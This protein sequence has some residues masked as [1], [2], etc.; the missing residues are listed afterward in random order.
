MYK[1][2]Q[3]ISWTNNKPKNKSFLVKHTSSRTGSGTRVL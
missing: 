3:T 1:S 2:I